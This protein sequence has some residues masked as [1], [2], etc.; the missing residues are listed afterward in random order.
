MGDRTRRTARLQDDIARFTSPSHAPTQGRARPFA[1][2][3]RSISRTIGTT[4][5][6]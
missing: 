5:S 1:P 4:F 6:P 2:Q 3:S